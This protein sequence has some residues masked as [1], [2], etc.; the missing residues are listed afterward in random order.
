MDGSGST[1]V[2]GKFNDAY[3]KGLEYWKRTA[4]ESVSTSQ[5]YTVNKTTFHNI[6][7]SWNICLNRSLII[8]SN[9]RIFSN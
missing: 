4:L 8:E 1:S 7:I 5:G 9:F 6:P 3:E 2:H